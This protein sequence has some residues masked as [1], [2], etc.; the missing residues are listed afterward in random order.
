MVI[1]GGQM[2][3]RY[4]KCQGIYESENDNKQSI[5][6]TTSNTNERAEM[7]LSHAHTQ[8]A[9]MFRW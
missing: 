2:K 8:V 9:E 5:K 4:R 1:V 6:M 7:T 3:T